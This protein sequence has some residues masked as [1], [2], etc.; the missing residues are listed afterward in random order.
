GPRFS[1]SD[2][3]LSIRG[4]RP[5]PRATR[6]RPSDLAAP[7]A[8][9]TDTVPLQGRIVR[10]P[11]RCT[12]PCDCGTASGVVGTP[13][14]AVRARTTAGRPSTGH[15]RPH[16]R[17]GLSTAP[18]GCKSTTP[19][20]GAHLRGN[21]HDG[22]RPAA[23]PPGLASRHIQT[24]GFRGGEI[25]HTNHPESKDKPAHADPE[26]SSVSDEFR[27]GPQALPLRIWIYVQVAAAN[28]KLT[29]DNASHA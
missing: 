17:C 16:L 14:A 13:R 5:L 12:R 7:G 23:P 2:C 20:R 4:R 11:P 3:P 24:V 27:S 10:E 8:T 9:R 21:P 19:R 25:S 29:K 28:R 26:A 15:G 1:E 6:G 18:Q 22:I